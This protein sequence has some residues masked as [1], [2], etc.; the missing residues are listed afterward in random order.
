MNTAKQQN[1]EHKMTKETEQYRLGTTSLL[2]NMQQDTPEWLEVRKKAMTS[3]DI[4]SCIPKTGTKQTTLSTFISHKNSASVDLSTNLAIQMGKENEPIILEEFVNHRLEHDIKLPKF[5]L[6]TLRAGDV[7]TRKIYFHNN[8]GDE[9][10]NTL[11]SSHDATIEDCDGKLYVIEIKWSKEAY[12]YKNPSYIVP[13][14]IKQCAH[15]LL[16]N[17][18]ADSC[19]LVITDLEG[20]VAI[21][22]LTRNRPEILGTMD[23]ICCLASSVQIIEQDGAIVWKPNKGEVDLKNEFL[24][25]AGEYAQWLK[26]HKAAMDYK[27]RLEIKLKGIPYA[28]T[29]E[30]VFSE[31]GYTVSLHMVSSTAFNQDKYVALLEDELLKNDISLPDKGACMVRKS[32]QELTAR[33]L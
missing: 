16:V 25:T 3:T 20:Q 18:K 8:N 7:F 14:F 24:A 31:Y 21:H 1:K 22:H 32:Y 15:H 30:A 2:K 28:P 33:Q 6:E 13:R 5:N 23:A 17:E 27:K 19:F 10:E 4:A 12:H 29:V 11:L 26:D 9:I